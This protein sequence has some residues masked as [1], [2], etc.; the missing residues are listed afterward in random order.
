M[1]LTL[2]EVAA[3]L[4][5]SCGAAECIACD[6][7]I[8]SRTLH[9]GSLFFAI[10][11][12]H[13]DGHDF[14]AQAFRRGAAG[15]VVERSFAT[16]LAAGGASAPAWVSALIPVDDT[17]S[18]LQDLARMVRRR[19]GRRLVAVTGSTGKT[20]TKELI[21]AVLGTRCSTHKS[22]GNLNNQYGVPL[23]LLALQPAH[24]AAVLELG[25]SAAGEIAHL[26][27]LAEPQ[28]GVVTNVAAAHLQFFS[29]VDAIAGA[30]RELI[31]N[32]KCPATAV[33]NFD[34]ERVR[35]FGE[36]FT[37]RII[38]FGFGEGAEIRA[39]DF[40]LEPGQ[41]PDVPRSVFSV[42]TPRGATE[43]DLSLPGR[44]N[45]ENAL[46]AVAVA[47]VFDIPLRDV[48]EALRHFQPLYQRTEIVRLAEGAVVINDSY[49]SNPRAME[50]ML[51]VLVAWPGAARR[52]VVAGQ[53]LELGADSPEL[54]RRIGRRL[55]ERG[56]DLLIGVQGDAECFVEGAV[57]AGMPSGQARFFAAAAEAGRFCRGVVRPGDVI[58]VK[59]SRGV[60][61]ETVIELLR[62]SQPSAFGH[63]PSALGNRGSAFE[64]GAE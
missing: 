24:E 15:A 22:P 38:T 41:E 55:A 11:G 59:G 35:R 60:H 36:G 54:H 6:Y 7:S 58:L 25:M 62:E 61:L 39:R 49:N 32:L 21:A 27:R 1:Q 37:G 3:V 17:T 12:P 18:A 34:D 16:G 13:F 47:E 23:A 43:F 56:V 57:A 30:K 48:V 29:S 52:I 46:A 63:Q 9:P 26:A 5:A 10:R 19:W 20:T 14:V 2:G 50:Q 40:R 33:L 53:M 31:E 44:H 4:G 8:D 28:I 42:R 45:V 64:L 51:D